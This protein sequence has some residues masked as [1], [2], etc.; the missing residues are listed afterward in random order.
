MAP[1]SSEILQFTV[2]P[3]IV[4]SLVVEFSLNK[5]YLILYPI[6]TGNPFLNWKMELYLFII[7]IL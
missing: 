2:Y 7:F 5:I 3:L 4:S 6:V 1:S